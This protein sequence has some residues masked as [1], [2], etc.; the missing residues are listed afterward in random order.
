M[1]FRGKR[2]CKTITVVAHETAPV[3]GYP[4]KPATV[5]IYRINTV[6][7]KTCLH[8]EKRDVIP[9]IVQHGVSHTG[10]HHYHHHNY[11]Y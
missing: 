7:G 4:Y 8:V 3:C 2:T 9:I 10:K 11:Q 5:F 6:V 1:G